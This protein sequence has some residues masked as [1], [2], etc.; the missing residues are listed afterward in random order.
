[1]DTKKK[2]AAEYLG[3]QAED[4]V[5]QERSDTLNATFGPKWMSNC[6]NRATKSLYIASK[7]TYLVIER[8]RTRFAKGADPPLTVPLE[9][10]SIRRKRGAASTTSGGMR[11]C[12]FPAAL[13]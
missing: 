10:L 13:K 1:M 4:T 9:L 12:P 7:H 5:F 3:L 6:K 2:S 8:M 11:I